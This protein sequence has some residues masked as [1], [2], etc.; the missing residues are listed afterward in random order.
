MRA[1]WLSIGVLLALPAVAAE[2]TLLI[3][4]RYRRASEIER[5]LLPENS[6]SL[7]PPGILAWTV[8]ERRNAVSVTGSEAAIQELRTVIRLLDVPR[9][10][11][12]LRVRLVRLE[13]DERRELGLKPAAGVLPVTADSALAGV[14]TYLTP[15]QVARLELKPSLAA[16]EMTVF[17]NQPLRMRWPSDQP[18]WATLATLVPRLNADGSV[19]LFISTREPHPLAPRGPA[20][21]MVLRRIPA[22]A[23]IAVAPRTPGLALLVGVRDVQ[24]RFPSPRRDEGRH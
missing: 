3:P 10:S 16:T 22:G 17:N 15:E 14:S 21:L 20:E 9:S 5:L 2:K 12:R 4:M 13:P 23:A 24:R 11:V 19:T 7:V 1:L 8:D 6:T 18:G